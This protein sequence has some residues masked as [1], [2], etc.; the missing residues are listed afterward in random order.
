[1]STPSLT[2]NFPNYFGNQL[3]SV[4]TIA[5]LRLFSVTGLTD[6]VN[7]LVD[8]SLTA[9]DGAGAYFVWSAASTATDDN[10]TVI[11]PTSVLVG[12]PGRWLL[13][14]NKPL[15]DHITDL[16]TGNGDALIKHKRPEA[17]A[18]QRL[19]SSRNDEVIYAKDYAGDALGGT[20]GNDFTQ[21]FRDMDQ[22]APDGAIFDFSHGI[23]TGGDY[24]ITDTVTLTKHRS[25]RGRNSRIV[26]VMSDN[27]KDLIVY[28]PTG[29]L[30]GVQIQGMRLAFNAGG[31]HTLRFNGGNNGV[32]SNVVSRCSISSGLGGY[33]IYID[34]LGNHFNKIENCTLTGTATATGAVY[35]GG[36]DGTKIVDNNITGIGHG[37]KVNVINGAYKTA[38]IGGTITSRDMG[39]YITAGQQIDIERVQ[40]EQGVGNVGTNVNQATYKAHIVLLGTGLYPS[41]EEVRD[42]RIIGNNFRKRDK[43]RFINHSRSLHERCHYR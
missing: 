38:I 6:G 11:R 21:A 27:T 23:D 22:Y 19:L 17:P 14:G 31:R 18:V 15:K 39:V 34:G 9:G 2:I 40:F 12:N 28:Q 41:G 26:G 35:L 4:S 30:R 36:A 10:S 25:L 29:E 24:K 42:V 3:L 8:G 32:I 20:Y 33:G 37:V 16:A 1:M 13:F 7:I 43:Q 5:A